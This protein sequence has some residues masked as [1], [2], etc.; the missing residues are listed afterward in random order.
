MIIK[1]IEEYMIKW[2]KWRRDREWDEVDKDREK[3]DLWQRIK[4]E[5]N[6][7]IILFVE[8]EKKEEKKG[9][10]KRREKKGK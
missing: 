7:A 1:E 5:T 4:R 2:R 3:P 8:G 10:K 9:G 6:T